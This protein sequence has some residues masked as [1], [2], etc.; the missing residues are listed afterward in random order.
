AE[1][2]EALRQEEE[3]L[4]ALEKRWEQEKALVKQVRALRDQIEKAHAGAKGEVARPDAAPL[5]AELEA[6]TSELRMLQG[7]SP[8]MQV[9]VDAQTVAEVVAGWTGIPVGK[10]M[11]DQIHT[12]LN[13]R[14]KLEERII[15]Q[16]QALDVI[17]QR[18]WT[19][20]ASLTDPRR[21]I[22]VFL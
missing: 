17:G 5:M 8:L 9:C 4:A 13:L 10:M 1:R 22:G 21:P 2:A 7:E 3:R 12:V 14:P 20:R 19:A 6:R 15:G 11:A 18:I 16:S